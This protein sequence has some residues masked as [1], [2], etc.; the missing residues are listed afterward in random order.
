MPKETEKIVRYGACNLWSGLDCSLF[1]WLEGLVIIFWSF[2]FSWL[3]EERRDWEEEEGTGERKEK[4][5]WEGVSGQPSSSLKIRTKFEE[6]QERNVYMYQVLWRIYCLQISEYDH[7]L[8]K[9][10]NLYEITARILLDLCGRQPVVFHDSHLSTLL[11]L[12]C[13]NIDFSY[14]I[15]N[16]IIF[17]LQCLVSLV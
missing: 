17:E 6:L 10:F 1:G 9:T 14:L 2:F 3:P 15:F 5:I 11:S 12:K 13:V 16:F 7:P 4:G 8:G